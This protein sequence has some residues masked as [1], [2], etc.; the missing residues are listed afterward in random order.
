MFK[1]IAYSHPILYTVGMYR[2]RREARAVF[3]SFARRHQYAD[4]VELNEDDIRD[5]AFDVLRTDMAHCVEYSEAETRAAVEAADLDDLIE[6]LE[7]FE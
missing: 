2:S 7:R 3:E 5:A 6:Y 4:L 1:V